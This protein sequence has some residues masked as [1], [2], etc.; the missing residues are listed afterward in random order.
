MRAAS[1]SA[2]ILL[3]EKY[4][5]YESLETIR[6]LA[7]IERESE[8]MKELDLPDSKTTTPS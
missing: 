8:E 4:E 6:T 5:E 2:D 7:R 3:E 1:L